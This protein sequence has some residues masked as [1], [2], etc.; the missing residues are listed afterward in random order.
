M[1]AV[2]GPDR[3][4][5]G[6]DN[7]LLLVAADKLGGVEEAVEIAEEDYRLAPV[8]APSTGA[9]SSRRR[10]RISRAACRR[11]TGSG[12]RPRALNRSS[13]RRRRSERADPRHRPLRPQV[14]QRA[15]ERDDRRPE[16]G[17]NRARLRDRDRRRLRAYFAS[18]ART[19]ADVRAGEILL[20]ED[21][22]RNIALAI[23]AG[24]AAEMF[25][26]PLGTELRIRSR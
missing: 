24:N 10:R 3:L 16:P 19:F 22:Y 15:G 1:I 17:G 9:T 21:S 11:P 8:S 5:V 12:A 4:Y 2:R 18:V 14:R 20:Y 25:S 23:N 13:F 7:G 26:T 6:P